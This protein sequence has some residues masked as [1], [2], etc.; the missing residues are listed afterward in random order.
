MSKRTQHKQRSNNP[1]NNNKNI[2]GLRVC[3]CMGVAG[4]VRYLHTISD[5]VRAARTKFKVVSR[6]SGIKGK[7]VGAV[8]SKLATIAQRDDF[9]AF[10]VRVDGHVLLLNSL[11]ETAIDTDPRKRDRRKITHVFGVGRK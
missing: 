8:R 6:G 11:G 5:V 10:I 3:E 4:N 1:E 7:T 2:C 9:T